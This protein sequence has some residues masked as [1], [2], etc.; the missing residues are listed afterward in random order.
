MKSK[1]GEKK[2]VGRVEGGIWR[3]WRC[4]RSWGELEQMSGGVL[5]EVV[6]VVVCVWGGW[7]LMEV[8]VFNLLTCMHKQNDADD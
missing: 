7:L 1:Q 5:W 8:G 2:K 4:K 6:V 3:C